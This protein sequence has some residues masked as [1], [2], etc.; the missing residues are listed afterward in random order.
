MF[1]EGPAR[2][3]LG[4][5]LKDPNGILALIACPSLKTIDSVLYWY[6]MT[7]LSTEDLSPIVRKM[8]FFW[9]QV[10]WD[11]ARTDPRIF[12]GMIAFTLGRKQALTYEEAGSA[13]DLQHASLAELTSMNIFRQRPVEQMSAGRTLVC[14]GGFALMAL[15][16]GDREQAL[17]H[18]RAMASNFTLLQ[19]DEC[20]WLS[21]SWV[22]LRIASSGLNPPLLSYYIPQ[23]W[24]DED[25]QESSDINVGLD[26]CASL[27]VRQLGT[28]TGLSL[29]SAFK[30]FRNLHRSTY[31]VENPLLTETPPYAVLFDLIYETCSMEG[32]STDTWPRAHRGLILVALKLMG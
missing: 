21:T 4:N 22:D 10:L 32:S 13:R 3:G 12:A 19:P 8:Q 14:M 30:A 15:L 16:N 26:R 27:N 9:G 23:Y 5:V 18:L 28:L 29:F 1:P 25:A 20:E 7:D 24:L 6:T 11:L 31:L 2:S 17:M